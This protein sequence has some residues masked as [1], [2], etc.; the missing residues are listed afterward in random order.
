VVV[1]TADE[2]AGRVARLWA[3]YH[4]RLTASST[5]SVHVVAV[6]APHAIHESNEAIVAAAVDTV[7]SVVAEGGRL[8][9]CRATFH[10]VGG[11][12]LE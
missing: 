3:G 7:A 2:L 5:D 8:P 9:A 12:C 11:R 4:D 10:D 1:L 6:D